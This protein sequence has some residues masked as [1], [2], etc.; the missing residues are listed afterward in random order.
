MHRFVAALLRVQSLRHTLDLNGAADDVMGRMRQWTRGHRKKEED[1]SGMVRF[2]IQ[3][4]TVSHSFLL[5]LLPPPLQYL[6]AVIPYKTPKDL[7]WK[8]AT[9]NLLTKC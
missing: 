7:K 8:T 1:S 4:D 6:Q 5:S 9:L 2:P 3:S